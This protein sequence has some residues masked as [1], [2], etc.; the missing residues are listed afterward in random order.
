MKKTEYKKLFTKLSSQQ[1]YEY[2]L[3]VINECD[4]PVS[5][6]EWLAE[7]V[8]KSNKNEEFAENVIELLDYKN[9]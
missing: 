3:W 4:T 9:K 7:V 1:I 2:A 8:M 6:I 5:E